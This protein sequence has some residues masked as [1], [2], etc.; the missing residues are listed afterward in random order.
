MCRTVVSMGWKAPLALVDLCCVKRCLLLWTRYGS[1]L[2][3]SYLL[4]I[5]RLVASDLVW[6]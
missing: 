2:N 3:A 5:D 4:L 6:N 1:K